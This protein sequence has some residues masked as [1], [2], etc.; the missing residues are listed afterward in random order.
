[1]T[2]KRQS[3]NSP[4]LFRREQRQEF[5]YILSVACAEILSWSF[6]L[7]PHLIRDLLADRLGDLF[8]R[9]TH[10]YRDNVESNVRQAAGVELAPE[11]LDLLTKSIFRASARNFMDLITMPRHSR[12]WFDRSVHVTG[13]DWQTIDDAVASEKGVIFLTAHVGCFDF[14]GQAFWARGYKL[15][16]VTGRT[17][18]RFIF[19]GV[20]HLRAAKGAKLVE[21]TPS[22]VRQVIKAL[23]RGECAVILSDRDF[24]Q[25]GR[26]VAFFGKTTTLPPGIVRIARDTGAIVIPIFTRRE[27]RGHGL[28]ILSTF[29]VEKSRDVKADIDRGLLKVADVL[30]HGIRASL[31]QWAMF[32]RVWPDAPVEPVRVFPVGSPLES[33]LLERVAA[34]LPERSV[35]GDRP[36]IVTRLRSAS[37]TEGWVDDVHDA[38][39]SNQR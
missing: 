3:T 1:V 22:G 25:S 35:D 24:F 7:I 21:P 5:R 4:P 20:T 2:N 31:D 37:R 26:E 29:T 38:D 36:S 27:K 19:D 9:S 33:E 13:G 10:T 12:R 39:E 6:W 15:T 28:E 11:A 18:S 34:A 30:E 32:Q 8:R 16:V 14:I 17:T 23:Q